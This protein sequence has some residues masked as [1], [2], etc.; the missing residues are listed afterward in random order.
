[1]KGKIKVYPY[2]KV[3]AYAHPELYVCN[4]SEEHG[5]IQNLTSYEVLTI[6]LC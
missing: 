2:F 6:S 5:R 4:G 1:L 3:S